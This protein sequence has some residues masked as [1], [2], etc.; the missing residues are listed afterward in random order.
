[1]QRTDFYGKNCF[2]GEKRIIIRATSSI[3]YVG[4][5]SNEDIVNED[6]LLIKTS[7]E[8]NIK[9]WIPTEEI[10]CIIDNNI[11]Y[12]AIEYGCST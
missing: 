1:M 8:M 7:P 5:I 4:S 3:S 12:S 6:G 2:S 9:V 11:L 10:D